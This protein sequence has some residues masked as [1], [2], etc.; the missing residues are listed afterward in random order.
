MLSFIGLQPIKTRETNILR[1]SPVK[2]SYV[3]DLPRGFASYS[4]LLIEKVMKRQ[5][6]SRR[7]TNVMGVIRNNSV[8]NTSV[9]VGYNCR[10]AF[11]LNLEGRL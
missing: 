11:F 4:L 6:G 7:D 1:V 3:V 5:W 2:L 9:S 8:Q 10:G